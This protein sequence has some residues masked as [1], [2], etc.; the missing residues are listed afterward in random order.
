[1]A[2]IL[3]QVVNEVLS[4]IKSEKGVKHEVETK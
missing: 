2:P 4:S 3:D 1:M